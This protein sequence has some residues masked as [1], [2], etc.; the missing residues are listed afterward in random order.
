MAKGIVVVQV[1]EALAEPIHPLP[2]E[3]EHRM[4]TAEGNARI[5]DTLGHSPQQTE[6]PI[7]LPQQQYPCVAGH[8][9]SLEFHLHSTPAHWRKQLDLSGTICHGGILS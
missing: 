4:G 3:A 2:Q 5:I 1:F 7:H 8:I 9:A 6:L